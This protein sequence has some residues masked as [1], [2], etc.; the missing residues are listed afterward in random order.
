MSSIPRALSVD[1]G[2]STVR[3]LE[4]GPA[5]KG[6]LEV[7]ALAEQEIPFDPGKTQET[8]PLYLQAL[9]TAL[10]NLGSKTRLCYLG[11][12]GPSVFARLLKIPVL[13]PQKTSAMVAFEAQQVIPAIEQAAWGHQLFPSSQPGEVDALILAIKKDTVGEMIAATASVGLK[14]QAVTLTPAALI[15]AFAYNYPEVTA[16]TILVEIGARASTIILAEGSRYFIRVVPIGGAT[17]S[18][19]VAT[20]LQENFSGAE[21]IK[22]AKGFVHPGGAYEDPPDAVAAR[23]SKLARGVMSRLHTEV[24]RTVTFFRSQQGGGK[25]VQAWLAG[26]GALLG[27]TDL[28]FQEK[29]KIPVRPFQAF[30]RIPV[31][32][33][34]VVK[35]PAVWGTALGAALEA[36]PETP[37]RISVQ[38][39]DNLARSQKERDFPA[40]LAGAISLAI[41]C[42]FPGV[43]GFWQ[44]KK[45]ENRLS[46]ETQKVEAAEQ[47]WGELEK[48]R[49]DFS[50]SAAQ[51]EKI[52]DLE[53]ERMRWPR[54]LEE[55]KVRA[56]PGLWITSLKV[57]PP[58]VAPAAETNPGAPV[59]SASGTRIPTV[60]IGGM[61]ETKSEKAD[62]EAVENFQKALN[63]GKVLTNVTV[64]ERETPSYREGKTD[65]VALRFQLR[66]DWPGLN[67]ESKSSGKAGARP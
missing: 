67:E 40:L 31:A 37:V 52:M 38:G 66:A 10:S 22:R 46:D 56:S 41:L 57:I 3:V 20:D 34:V 53:K 63:E 7:L 21:I 43:H 14:V 45:G 64:L 30:R 2:A 8:L 23:I 27:Y 15:N 65:Q 26:G 5:A 54:L 12:G 59:P 48:A 55:L 35:N 49:K 4:F 36:L 6:G 44:A 62:A 50:E 11:L 33:G 16:A 1:F 60:E 13:D 32:S 51:A 42:F 39:A 25:P 18:Q 28:F 9:T 24:E 17:I 47:A 19:A 58:A 61:F 29:L